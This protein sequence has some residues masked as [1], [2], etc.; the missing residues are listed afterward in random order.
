MLQLTVIPLVTVTV[1]STTTKHIFA[2]WSVSSISVVSPSEI[3]FTDRSIGFSKLLMELLSVT[4]LRST[5]SP[6]P[7]SVARLIITNRFIVL[8]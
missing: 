3:R 7:V 1:I 8:S 6:E 2:K 4:L 5:T